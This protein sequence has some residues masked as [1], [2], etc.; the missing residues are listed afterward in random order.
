MS[1]R[2]LH[3]LDWIALSD[4][5]EKIKCHILFLRSNKFLGFYLAVINK[6]TIFVPNL[7]HIYKRR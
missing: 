3:S 1:Y 5:E 2:Q 7:V 4:M 6:V